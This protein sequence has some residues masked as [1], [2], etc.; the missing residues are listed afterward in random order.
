MPIVEEQ[1]INAY[2]RYFETDGS[3]FDLAAKLKITRE[4][5]WMIINCD[6]IGVLIK[7]DESDLNYAWRRVTI[8]A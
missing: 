7:V 4:N 3:P 1:E 5:G 2:L 8:G 6:E